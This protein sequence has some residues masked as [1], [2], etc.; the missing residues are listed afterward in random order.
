MIQVALA[1]VVNGSDTLI[2]RRMPDRHMGD[3]WEFPGGKVEE[4][5]SPEHAAVRELREETGIEGR[6]ERR[7]AVL[8]YAY[9]DRTVRL[10]A[11][12]C[13]VVDGMAEAMDAEE[14]RW[15]PIADLP[16]YRFP[17]ANGPL[18]QHL[19]EAAKKNELAPRRS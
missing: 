15:A 4:G 13:R 1:V 9:G 5:E 8:D 2:A 11:F 19:V 16:T 14:V 12:L 6:V 18:I 7:L 10:H 3:H 17:P